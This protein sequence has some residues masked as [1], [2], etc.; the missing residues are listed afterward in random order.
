MPQEAGRISRSIGGA[1]QFQ[2]IARPKNSSV[3]GRHFFV[4]ESGVF[5][6]DAVADPGECSPS[7]LARFPVLNNGRWMVVGFWCLRR[8]VV[9]LSSQNQWLARRGAPTIPMVVGFAHVVSLN[10]AFSINPMDIRAT[11]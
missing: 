4:D 7:T 2:V 10:G 11:Y 9:G 8:M 5:R 6:R 1:A 3:S